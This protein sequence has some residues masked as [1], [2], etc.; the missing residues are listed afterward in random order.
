MPS[1]LTPPAVTL[2]PDDAEACVDRLRRLHDAWPADVVDAIC[3]V[4]TTTVEGVVT[5]QPLPT[6]SLP[7]LPTL[8]P[9][10]E[11]SM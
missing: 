7:P 2:R 9:A 6:A 4:E 8:P 11:S 10:N 5:A 1:F 3:G